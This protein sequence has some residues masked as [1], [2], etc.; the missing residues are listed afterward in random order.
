M[1]IA[2]IDAALLPQV[3]T[4]LFVFAMVFG[5]LTYSKMGDFSKNINGVLAI[6]IA[7]FAILYEPLVIGLTEY[8]PIAVGLLVVL[9]FAALVKKVLGGGKDIKDTF[10]L[11]IALGILLLLLGLFSDQ[12]AA[13]L[14]AGFDAGNVLWIIGI[15]V[16]V[17]FF[18]F[19]YKYKGSA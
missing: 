15:V 17:L 1:A 6:A 13:Y 5:V 3:S 8:M 7:F 19:I 14:P 16:V 18:W 4:F 12:L 9:F 2:F 10:P 11:I